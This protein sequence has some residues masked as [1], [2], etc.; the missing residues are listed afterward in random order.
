VILT[1][2]G[3]LSVTNTSPGKYD[4]QIKV[5]GDILTEDLHYGNY[6]TEVLPLGTYTVEAIQIGGGTDVTYPVTVSQCQTVN[7]N[8]P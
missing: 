5:N 7:Q 1:G 6:V 8:I 2:Y 3:T 4:Y